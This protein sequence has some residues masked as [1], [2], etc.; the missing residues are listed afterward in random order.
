[1]VDHGILGGILLYDRLV[2]IRRK[3]KEHNEDNLFWGKKLENQY[4]LAANAIS[5]HNIWIPNETNTDVYKQYELAALPILKKYDQ[6]TFR[7][8]T[9]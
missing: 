1:M 2:K 8:S 9:C 4:K 6:K 3:K 7:C 5:L